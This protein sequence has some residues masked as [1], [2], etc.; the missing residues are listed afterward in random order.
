LAAQGFENGRMDDEILDVASDLFRVYREQTRLLGDHKPPI[1]QRLQAYLND[2]FKDTGD[3]DIP[4][5]PQQ[6]LTVDRYGLARELSFPPEAQ[7]FHNCEID[8]YRLSNNGVLHNPINDKRTTE[9]VF[10]G[11]FGKLVRN[12]CPL[13]RS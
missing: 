9:G 4:Q 11:E 1:D 3:P 7:E 2:V 10:H 6:T 5:L 12:L 13:S 8:S